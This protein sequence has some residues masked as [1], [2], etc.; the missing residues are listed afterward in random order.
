MAKKVTRIYTGPDGESHFEDTEIAVE[1]KMGINRQ[2][3]LIKAKEII[4]G[5]QDSDYK[6][7]WHN[8]SRRQFVITL[9]GECEI[10]IGDGAK[11]KFKPGD[12]LL[13]E[14]ITGRGHITRVVNA[15]PRKILIVT[16]E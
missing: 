15:K 4:F 11:R 7:D 14:D 1:N 16:L 12:I 2:S 6:N 9:E 10:E 8:A 13:A 3:E 5:E